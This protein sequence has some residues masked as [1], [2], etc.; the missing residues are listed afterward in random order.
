[1]IS[2]ALID[3]GDLDGHVNGGVEA[4]RVPGRD[5][6]HV[7][8]AWSS[9]SSLALG[10]RPLSVPV[11]SMSE[12]WPHQPRSGGTG[13][14]RQSVSS[15]SARVSG[16]HNSPHG[17]HSRSRRLSPLTMSFTWIPVCVVSRCPSSRSGNTGAR[18]QTSSWTI[19]WSGSAGSSR[20]RSVPEPSASVYARRYPQVLTYRQ[21]PP[22]CN[23]S[24]RWHLLDLRRRL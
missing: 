23:R 5:R 12:R 16:N 13:C 11:E 1:M 10:P 4:L 22:A 20:Q 24:L 3:V 17:A 8:R 19:T 6:H 9:W 15:A 14:Y 2:G 18:F 21:Q 7:A